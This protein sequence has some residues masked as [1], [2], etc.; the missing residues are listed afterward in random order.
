MKSDTVQILQ[1]QFDSL[2]Q[3]IPGETVEFW[4]A[5]DLQCKG[6]QLKSETK[7][8]VKQSGWLLDEKGN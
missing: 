8:I 7:K 5:R 1:S 4:F 3:Q 6:G 2:C